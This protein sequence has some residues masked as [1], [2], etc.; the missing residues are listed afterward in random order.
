MTTTH[1]MLCQIGPVQSF[2]AAGRRT[3]DL[4]I[5]SRLLS[6]LV[7]A[8]VKAARQANADMLFPSYGDQ[9]PESPTGLSHR[10]AFIVSAEPAG[11]GEA[12][13]NAI[14]TEWGTYASRVHEWLRSEVGP[15][16]WE[17]VFERGRDNWLEFYWVVVPYDESRHAECYRDANAA[18]A[19]RKNLRH[20]PQIE[21]PGWKCTLT[22]ASS[23]LPL[24]PA[25]KSSGYAELRRAWERFSER[26]GGVIVRKNEMLG[27]V[28]MIKRFV[29]EA[30]N[31]KDLNERFPSTDEIAGRRV[32]DESEGKEVEGYLAVLHMDGDRMGEKLSGLK[33]KDA[34]QTFSRALRE[35]AVREVPGIVTSYQRAQLVYAGGDDVVALLPLRPALNCADRIRQ[36]YGEVMRDKAGVL[37]ATMSA[38]IAVV[39][40][41]YPLD[42]AIEIAREAERQAKSQY[43][44]DAVVI[45]EAH[46]TGHRRSAGAKW[47]INE[48]QSIASLVD[49]LI[50]VFRGED[51][52]GRISAKIGY[53]MLEIA[54]V[55]TGSA[56]KNGE[57]IPRAA[58]EAEL[59][60]LLKR[61]ALEGSS[62]EKLADELV[63]VLMV[64]GEHKSVGW[65]ALANWVIFARFLA[66]EERVGNRAS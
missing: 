54:Y 1:L 23:A 51:G 32:E 22:V 63:P 57:V 36:R 39:P 40:S 48:G 6:R 35:F 50:S 13:D 33:S 29:G 44:R 26:R 18:M 16:D 20:F 5:G 8:G 12:I 15:G 14:L 30:T 31:D 3:A 58:R 19:Q 2:I 34:H 59:R 53:D 62:A 25:T 55:L 41:N 56:L 46:G 45:T 17:E 21:E 4:H 61:R 52:D 49:R 9:T 24:P 27:A 11:V 65:E 60:R 37:G 7:Y 10:F 66:S 43:S 64:W 47:Q 28:A 42:L 38:G